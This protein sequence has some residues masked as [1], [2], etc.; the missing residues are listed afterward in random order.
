MK[1]IY[2][3]GPIRRTLQNTGNVRISLSY[4]DEREAAKKKIPNFGRAS[5]E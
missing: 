3:K 5:K 2:P 1:S 4:L